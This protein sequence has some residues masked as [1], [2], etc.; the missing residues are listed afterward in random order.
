MIEHLAWRV[1]T[2]GLILQAAWDSLLDLAHKGP[3]RL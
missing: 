2:W 1:W 3:R